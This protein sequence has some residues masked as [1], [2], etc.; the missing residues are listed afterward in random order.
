DAYKHEQK[1]TA[2]IYD[3]V[4]LATK[5]G[6]HATASMCKWFVDE[7]VEEEAQT[8]EIVNQ[9]KMLGDSKGS[10]FMLDR[11]LGKRE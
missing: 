10:L 3:I 9:I 2:M 11:Q 6:D 8:L 7:Q 4:N 1:V 5:E